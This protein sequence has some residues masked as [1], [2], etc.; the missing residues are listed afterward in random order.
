MGQLCNIIIGVATGLV[1]SFLVWWF[2][3]HFLVPKINFS[4]KIS[5]SIENDKP[6]YKFKFENAGSRKLIDLQINI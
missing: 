3:F 2:L 1:S 6:I 4:E 5:K